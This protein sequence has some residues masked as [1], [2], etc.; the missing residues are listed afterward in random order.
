ML[1]EAALSPTPPARQWKWLGFHL[2]VAFIGDGANTDLS[3]E[4]PY[5]AETSE[6]K[7]HDNLGC[8]VLAVTPCRTSH[9]LSQ[10]S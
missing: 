2:P 9:L 5:Q 4:P 7:D 8:G 10:S 3:T 6:K 1:A